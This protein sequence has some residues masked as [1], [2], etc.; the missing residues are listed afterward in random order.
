MVTD[1][2]TN[3]VP[4]NIFNRIKLICRC[5]PGKRQKWRRYP[6]GTTS[7]DEGDLD[8]EGALTTFVQSTQRAFTDP[9]SD[10]K[11]DHG[12]DTVDAPLDAANATD[13]DGQSP[14]TYVVIN[15]HDV[16]Q[17]TVTPKAIQILSELSEVL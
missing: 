12:S 6:T 9:I 10:A 14:A 16:M 5:R 15:S 7:D 3:A 11:S 2:N 13:R 17:L 8:Y 4:D 1:E